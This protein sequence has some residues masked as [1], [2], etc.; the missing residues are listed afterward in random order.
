MEK[1]GWV[2]AALAVFAAIA[3]TGYASGREIAL[4]FGQPGRAG[5]LGIV[6]AALVFGLLTGLVC[7]FA[8]RWRADSFAV[9]C[10]RMLGRRAATVARALY[11][12]LL[13]LTALAM[14]RGAGTLGALTL[15]LRCSFLWGAGAA[16]LLALLANLA[17]LKPL[18]WAGLALIA[19]G[20][21]FYVAL[22][23]DARPVRLY[24]HGAV[25]LALEDSIPAAIALALAYGAMNGCVAAGVAARFS[26]MARPARVGIGC[27]AMLLVMLLCM[28][29]SLARGGRAL[30]F[31]AAPTVLLAAR[32]GMLGFWLCAGLCFLCVAATLSAALGGLMDLARD[33]VSNEW[34]RC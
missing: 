22:A 27:G 5:W 28:N 4:F 32:W 15:P 20:L 24:L 33:R 13:G 21:A 25:E 17:R 23:L 26:C 31:Q 7:R 8:I 12:L 19:V 14:L 16:L 10:R 18:Y 3:G 2:R 11:G 9:L 29:A 30:L 34:K 6:V 1:R